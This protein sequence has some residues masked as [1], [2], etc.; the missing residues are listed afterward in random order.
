MD[1]GP[2]LLEADVGRLAG[3]CRD[4]LAEP[5][6]GCEA[7]A[8]DTFE[9]FVDRIDKA[10]YQGLGIERFTPYFVEDIFGYLRNV[11]CKTRILFDESLRA[12]RIH[13][14]IHGARVWAVSSGTVRNELR[15]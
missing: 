12:I 5:Q 6:V 13:C 4:Q 15:P 3:Q 11:G 2:A 8:E 9:G 10:G 1:L 14:Q 7:G